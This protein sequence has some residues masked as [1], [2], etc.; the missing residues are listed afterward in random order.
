M[1]RKKYSTF[2]CET[3]F[4]APSIDEKLSRIL[5]R[6]PDG[7]ERVFFLMRRSEVDT[8]RKL[9]LYP[10]RFI[11]SRVEGSRG[12]FSLDGAHR[13][14]NRGHTGEVRRHRKNIFEVHGEWIALFA[15]CKCRRRGRRGGD[16]IASFKCFLK[17]ATEHHARGIC[18]TIICINVARREHEGAEKDAPARLFS[19]P[20]GTRK[21]IIVEQC[22][23]PL[24]EP[25]AHAVE[26]REIGR[27]LG[28]HDDV[29]CR[30]RVGTRR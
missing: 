27:D 13:H 8:D 26:A 25:I 14:R 12:T 20:L 23:P 24:R 5:N 1:R 9:F 29:V 28:G 4:I 19:E 18:F 3:G 30:K 15:E 21:E 6:A 16:D 7:E 10:E 17:L 2:A 11:L 22:L